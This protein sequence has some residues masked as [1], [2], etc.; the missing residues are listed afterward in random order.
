MATV[1]R[2]LRIVVALALGFLGVRLALHS[3]PAANAWMEGVHLGLGLFEAF[4]AALFLF[5]TTAP[6][7]GSI[8]LLTIGTALGVHVSRGQM[9][10][11]L[12]IWAVL[13]VLVSPAALSGRL[14]DRA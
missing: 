8:L 14:A 3:R 7:G 12:V 4:G 1:R 13:V 9:P 5:T 11:A 10:V 2:V 6:L